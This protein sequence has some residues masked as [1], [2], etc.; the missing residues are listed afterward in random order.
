LLRLR[1][2][3]KREFEADVMRLDARKGD[4]GWLVWDSRRCE[5][6][7]HCAWVDD[8]TSEYGIYAMPRKFID[9]RLFVNEYRAERIAIISTSRLILIDPIADEELDLIEV[10]IS[11]PVPLD[12]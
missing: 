5:R 12:A 7:R 1:P 10:A 3:E 11:R 8:Q 2:S 4:L 9:G 6:V